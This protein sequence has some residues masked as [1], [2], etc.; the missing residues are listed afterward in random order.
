MTGESGHENQSSSRPRLYPV[1]E[2]RSPDGSDHRKQPRILK[3]TQKDSKGKP[4]LFQVPRTP[5]DKGQETGTCF[6]HQHIACSLCPDPLR[7]KQRIAHTLNTTNCLPTL[8]ID[9]FLLLKSGEDILLAN[10]NAGSFRYPEF[11]LKCR[12]Y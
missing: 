4:V 7:R 12:Y 9:N 3:E 11:S 2:S 5:P 6:I 10:L 8:N 1:I